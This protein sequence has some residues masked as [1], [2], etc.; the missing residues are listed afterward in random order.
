[1]AYEKRIYKI[2]ITEDAIREWQESDMKEA[3]KR[4]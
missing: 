2:N 1:V 4:S 3:L